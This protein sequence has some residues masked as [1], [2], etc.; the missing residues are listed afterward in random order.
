MDTLVVVTHR[1]WLFEHLASGADDITV[2][3]DFGLS[4]PDMTPPDMERTGWWMPTEHAARLLHAELPLHLQA[5]GPE[6][7]RRVPFAFTGR[8]I[9]VATLADVEAD[10]KWL[11]GSAFVKV[12]EFKTDDVPAGWHTDLPAWIELLHQAGVP[13]DSWLQLTRQRIPF[14][15]E[16]RCF[17]ANGEVTGTAVYRAGRMIFPDAAAP[18]E[19]M[20]CALN[21][22]RTVVNAMGDDQPNGYTLDVGWASD[23]DEW[24]VV[25]ANPAW[26]SNPY[27]A[28]P[29]GVR[30]S[31]AAATV[32][33]STSGDAFTWIPD[34]YLRQ[35]AAQRAAGLPRR[36]A[37]W[38][39]R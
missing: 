10:P 23:R 24:L 4:T 18:G 31:L 2:V 3:H 39:S 16:V 20:S 27:D 29:D 15:V 38:R 32:P 36:P 6:W 37:L 30:V 25:E 9:W 7:M 5:P 21:F 13:A 35:Y 22:A 1:N 8:D 11:R 14:D 26:S 28:S 34:P 12:A 33:G 17:I 19:V